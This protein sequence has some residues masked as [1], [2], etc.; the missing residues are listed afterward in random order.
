MQQTPI[1]SHQVP[2]YV[3]SDY[4]AFLEFVRTYYD[5]LYNVYDLNKLDSTIDID[6]SIES[7]L[8][9]FRKELDI[10]NLTANDTNR[11]N[12][13]H[14]KDFYTAKGTQGGIEMFFRLVYGKQIQYIKPWDSVLIPSNTPWILNKSI[15][16]EITTGDVAILSSQTKRIFLYD[17]NNTRYES[18]INDVV[19]LS[20]NLVEISLSKIDPTIEYTSFEFTDLLDNTVTGDLLYTASQVVVTAAGSGFVAG[21]LFED[22]GTTVEVTRV[23]KLGQILAARVIKFATYDD[24]TD[25]VLTI[26]PADAINAYSTVITNTIS[27]ATLTVHKSKVAQ[28]PGYY[29]SSYSNVLGYD[30]NL[31]D[32]YYYQKFSYATTVDLYLN[33]YASL[34]RQAVHPAGVK[35]F[36]IRAL[37][38]DL[39]GDS[40]VDY[41]LDSSTVQPPNVVDDMF[42]GS[43][44]DSYTTRDSLNFQFRTTKVSN[45]QFAEHLRIIYNRAAGSS[46]LSQ[47]VQFN[48]GSINVI[49][50][51]TK[52]FL[53]DNAAF[54][55]STISVVRGYELSDSSIFDDS[56]IV[57][58][59]TERS[60]F[61]IQA[62]KFNDSNIS[63]VKNSFDV[64]NVEYIA[65]D[66]NSEN[67]H[68]TLLPGGGTLEPVAKSDL[69]G[70]ND[71]AI[72]ILVRSVDGITTETSIDSVAFNDS[73]ITLSLT[74]GGATLAP[75]TSTDTV[76]F[77]DSAISVLTNAH[78]RYSLSSIETVGLN[79]SSILA[80]INK[81]YYTT[82][83]V[84]PQTDTVS[85]N[86]SAINILIGNRLIT[87]ETAAFNDSPVTNIKVALGSDQVSFT[88]PTN[89]TSCNINDL[90]IELDMMQELLIWHPTGF[91]ASDSEYPGAT[92]VHIYDYLEYQTVTTA[93]GGSTGVQFVALSENT[94]QIW[95]KKSAL[96]SGVTIQPATA[97][98][99]T[100]PNPLQDE[101]ISIFP[102]QFVFDG[103]G[104]GNLTIFRGYVTDYEEV[105]SGSISY[106]KININVV[107][108]NNITGNFERIRDGQGAFRM[109]LRKQQT[110]TQ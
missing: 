72:S 28:Y 81:L 43:T 39:I 36:G 95:L 94:A 17:G 96:D 52:L 83:N 33:K 67:I 9:Y 74:A 64:I 13:K 76:G 49:L 44:D 47:N 23:D 20:N 5:W 57:A 60:F 38:N 21:Q 102:S 70:F 85:L 97:Y 87:K 107:T 100:L 14:L 106:Y 3:R 19:T 48:D 71:T 29:G 104:N 103:T 90:A 110:I 4:P 66:D 22:S 18:Y 84:A 24:D 62:V 80:V 27:Q 79:D 93:S 69:V 77:N 42:H 11:T 30:C 86:D 88:A 63:V 41:Q 56:A 10:F 34:L 35:H 65:F 98:T 50:N 2:E 37:L 53:F 61:P 58:K 40:Q 6:E 75:Q 12:I 31:Q 15:F 46:T 92:D 68:I 108:K 32:S 101:S 25:I 91:N 73:Q 16:A 1:V 45:V 99:Y 82:F 7:F 78:D 51:K 26:V 59:L 55:D 109:I 8:V 54:N 105:I 89:F